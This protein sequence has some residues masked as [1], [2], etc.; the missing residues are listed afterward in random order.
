[1]RKSE[2]IFEKLRKKGEKYLTAKLKDPFIRNLYDNETD[3][4]F[5]MIYFSGKDGC[6]DFDYKFWGS[7]KHLDIIE[8]SNQNAWEIE[9]L[10]ICH[11]S[12]HLD[13]DPEQLLSITELVNSKDISNKILA[14]NM[15]YKIK[16][17]I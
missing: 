16:L 13:I 14:A 11:L 9:K 12:F 2:I 4:D 1:M 10:L 3:Y 6:F 7:T 17:I 8:F 5:N 15:L